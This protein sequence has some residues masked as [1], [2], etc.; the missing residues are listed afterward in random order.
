MPR[1][2]FLPVLALL[3]FTAPLPAKETPK[4]EIYA[5]YMGCFPAATVADYHHRFQPDETNPDNTKNFEAMIGG[6]LTNLPLMPYSWYDDRQKLD[7]RRSTEMEIQRAMR[8]GI[9]GFAIDAWAGGDGARKMFE[10][11]LDICEEKKWPF[12]V[13]ICL[14][15]AC[16]PQVKNDI[17][18]DT[19]TDYGHIGAIGETIRYLLKFKDRPNLARRD[20][21][22]LIFTYQT[23]S[24][25]SRDVKA[26]GR[27]ANEPKRWR[28][29]LEMLQIYRDLARKEFNEELYVHMDMDE[30][31][32]S[33]HLDFNLI[34]G[35]RGRGKPGPM[36]ADMAAYLSKGEPGLEP[37]DAIGGFLGRNF[38]PEWPLV[39][40][41]TIA[42]GGEWA[43]PIWHQYN[44]KANA[45]IAGNGTDY[46][47]HNWDQVRKNNSTLLQYITWNDYGEDTVIAPATQTRYTVFDLTG[48]QIAWWKNGAPPAVDRDKVYLTFRR[49]TNDA[50]I[51]PFHARRRLDGVFEVLTI[52]TAPATIRVPGWNETY[53]APAGLFVKQFPLKTGHPAAE[54]VRDGKVVLDVVSPDP[55]SDKGF[56]EANE[57]I[58]YSS[59]FDRQWEIDFPGVPPEP[60]A[61]YG[62]DD[63]DGLP[64]W[65]EMLWFGNFGDY[66]HTDTTKPSD[67]PDGDGLTNLQE[68][69]QQSN[70]R[71]A[72][73]KYEK[74]FVW[75]LENVHA[76]EKSFNPDPDPAGRRVWRYTYRAANPL[77]LDGKYAPM[78]HTLPQPAGNGLS[79]RHHIGGETGMPDADGYI[80]RRK[81]D[82]GSWKLEFKPNRNSAVV[83]AWTSPVNGVVSVRVV[84]ADQ[85]QG[86]SR[87][88]PATLTLQRDDPLETLAETSLTGSSATAEASNVAVTQGDTLYV[89][90][91]SP[92]GQPVRFESIEVKLAE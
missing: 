76:V 89:I 5:H 26:E 17:A 62:D 10:L 51:Y 82:D 19:I 74:G 15:P 12:Q 1:Q 11:M 55:I 8:I 86:D 92:R 9:D 63:R 57:M 60:H 87:F 49:Y 42:A 31:F 38:E 69:Q 39:A 78:P 37:Y 4:K 24:I 80:G 46:L 13:T 43:N 21:K 22:V 7:V 83:L 32:P 23:C 68:Y 2:I 30:A 34:P 44:N 3:C 66:R 65:Y 90:V 18:D 53:E 35:S 61:E 85:S 20:G 70:P 73:S 25:M 75:N 77:T 41:K 59:E 72:A 58:C 16:H 29:Y 47:R 79:M 88:S 64:N 54:V 14:D 67:D 56:R 27:G 33:S 28:N 50:P 91:T 36:I 40:E 6:K 81:Q 84:T 48:Y 52:L 45:L 71:V